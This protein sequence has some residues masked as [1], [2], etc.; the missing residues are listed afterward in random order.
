MAL[1]KT[2]ILRR[3]RG[4]RLEGRTALI[5]RMILALTL[6]AGIS[7][8]GSPAHAGG[9]LI[10]GMTAGDLPIT[11]GNPDQGFEGYRFVGYN[12]YDSLVLW[13]LSQSDKPADIKP[14]LATEWQVD[15]GNPKRWI[16]KLRQGVKWHDGCDFKADDVVW[17]MSR[18]TNDKAPE[19]DPS[20]FAQ[21]RSYLG[22]FAGVQ[23]IDDYTVAFDTKAPDSLFPYEISY[24]LLISP[25]RAK[26]VKY[27]W[28]QYAL[29]P[30]GT[31]PYR[32]DRSVPHQ[33]LEFVPNAD[34]WDKTRAPKQDRLVLIPMP[35]ASTR[36]AALLSGQV[37]WIE[38]PSPDAIDRLKAA[39]MQIVTNV[40]P[41][42]WTYQ[43]NFVKGPFS[44]KRVRQAAN[45]ALNRE[46]M[47]ELLNGLMLEGY[48]TV[49]PST[50]Y[51]GHPLLYK[52]DPDKAK[53][54]LKQAGCLPCKVTFAISTSGSGQMQPLPMNELVKSQLDAVGFDVKLE[55]MDWNA[56]LQLTRAG[57]DDYPQINAINV[58]RQ[59]QDPF[60]ALIRHVW[61]AQWAPKGSNWGH[62]SN[63]EVDKLV[64]QIFGEFDATKRLALLTKLNETMN[65]EAALIFV[66]H[67]L[68]PRGLSPKVHGFVQAQSWF[69][70]LT[71]VSVEP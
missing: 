2:L 32:Y 22:N 6:G 8:A 11:T 12:L 44:D 34:Y 46:D 30:S 26:E 7:F 65:E 39:G 13:D 66:A 56:L 52:H 60:N 14:G 18:S 33:R 53:A 64:E 47:K 68:N 41:H 49:P 9:T 20:Q 23:K 50:P 17:N 70:D 16:F 1:R 36:T 62:Y 5:Q 43:L 61:T 21:A 3:P 45:Y 10:V 57:V 48:S 24:V 35:E 55:T 38:A 31:G 58:S 67:D 28:A 37:N 15:E 25:C 40:Y 4:G 54:L 59:T 69:Q 29:R 42:N 71:R 63:P 27:D 19:F 51:Y